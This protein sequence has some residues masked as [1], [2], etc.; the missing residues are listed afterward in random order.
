MRSTMPAGSNAGSPGVRSDEPR[1]RAVVLGVLGH[2]RATAVVQSLG[3]AGVPVVGVEDTSAPHRFHSR[4]LTEKFRISAKSDE[5]L[6]FLEGLGERGGGLL[7]PTDDEYL[8]LVAKNHDRLS[9]HFVMTV[10]PWDVL[11]RVMDPRQLYP[12]ARHAGVRT[13]AW[14]EPGNEADLDRIVGGL[15]L[16]GHDYVLKT[17][18]GTVPA[19]LRNGRF[20]KPAGRDPATVRHHSLEIASRLGELPL[21]VEVVPGEADRCIGVSMVVGPDHEP[22]AAYCTKRLKL[23]AYSRGGFVHPYELGSNVYCE[24]VHD[25]EAVELATR[26]VRVAGYYGVITVEFRRDPR[27]GGLVLIKGDPRFVRA[28]SLSAALGLDAPAILYRAFTNERIETPP[29]YPAGIGWFWPTLYLEAL[30]TNRSTRSIRCE[31]VGLLGNARR[32]RAFAH[33]SVRDPLP[34]LLHLAWRGRVWLSAR[35]RGLARKGIALLRRR[36]PHPAS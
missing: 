17:V 28:T 19:E 27:D 13:P 24:S 35:L 30:W 5:V 20:T 2:P 6:A 34:F 29:S 22:L 3:R 10:P 33:L 32:I 11:E 36:V 7:I 8:L 26:L 23:Y 15:D 31:L 14:F 1:P 4:Y 21:L 9:R 16:D 18:P 12:I 25:P